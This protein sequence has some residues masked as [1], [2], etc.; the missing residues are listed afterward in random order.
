MEEIGFAF[1]AIRAKNRIKNRETFL[2][3]YP[4]RKLFIPKVC[5]IVNSTV[6]CSTCLTFQ[7][8]NPWVTSVINADV[9]L[10]L[11]N[12][13]FATSTYHQNSALRQLS[14]PLAILTT[15]N[16]DASEGH[17]PATNF[18]IDD[19]NFAKPSLHFVSVSTTKIIYTHFIPQN[20]I[21][22]KAGPRDGSLLASHSK[23]KKFATSILHFLLK[24][25]LPNTS[26]GTKNVTAELPGHNL[27]FV[28]ALDPAFQQDHTKLQ[29]HS[30]RNKGC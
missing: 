27:Y 19:N 1:R 6:Y 12:D 21:T 24:W 18:E 17:D 4:P 3:K 30:T 28:Q 22:L 25:S 10:D 14:T 26:K 5:L 2:I 7:K 15:A 11:E 23:M 20:R 16:N 13:N 8:T 29:G 9:C